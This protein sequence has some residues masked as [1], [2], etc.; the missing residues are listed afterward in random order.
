MSFENRTLASA[1][2]LAAGLLLAAPAQAVDLMRRESGGAR[3]GH[4]AL[5]AGKLDEAVKHYD[6]VAKH[7]GDPAALAALALAKGT[8]LAKKGQDAEA[9]AELLRAT[10]AD[11]LAVRAR[12]FYN[13]GTLHLEKKRH[14]E[15]I[16]ALKHALR[17]SPADRDAKWNLELALRERQKEEERKKKEQEKQKQEQKKDEQKQQ[18]KPQDK[19]DQKPEDQKPDP[20][21][22]DPKQD[23]K[24]EKQDQKDKKPDPEKPS[25][26]PEPKKEPEKKPEPRGGARPQPPKSEQQKKMESVLDAL[27]RDEKNLQKQRRRLRFRD[28]PRR[29]EKDW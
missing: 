11:D 15:A 8:A 29:P 5:K 21:K 4:D 27:D 25:P 20:K 18:Q 10:G 22:Q 26:R 19:Q 16:A 24:P 14:D 3:S 7:T 6:G 23:R 12:A 9:R 28:R 2:V 1:L 17:L 13:L